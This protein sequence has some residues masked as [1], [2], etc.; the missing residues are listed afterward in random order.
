MHSQQ[1]QRLHEWMP[2]FTRD[3][4][5]TAFY[6]LFFLVPP[7]RM[8]PRGRL[9][10]RIDYLSTLLAGITSSNNGQ[11]HPE[12]IWS[13]PVLLSIRSGP[14][15]CPGGVRDISHCSAARFMGTHGTIS[16]AI[17]E[18]LDLL[19]SVT[20]IV[21]DDCYWTTAN[22]F[23]HHTTH[24]RSLAGTKAFLLMSFDN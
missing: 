20:F 21:D 5:I 22:S 9:Y 2:F 10:P 16:I 24:K 4:E 14:G 17:E 1:C 3:H 7:A 18:T 11:K 6:Y 19:S 23:P 12:Q 15:H 8:S 13:S